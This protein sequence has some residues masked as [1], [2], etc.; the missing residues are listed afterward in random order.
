MKGIIDVIGKKWALLVINAIGNH[1]RIRFNELMHELNKVSPRTL[2]DTL[3]ELRSAGLVTRESFSE[4]P[5][6]VEYFLTT[7]G[8]ELRRSIVPLLQWALAR[9]DSEFT[10]CCGNLVTIQKR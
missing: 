5:P 7:D 1:K 3:K 2:N 10:S 6:R 8:I 4:I 9:T